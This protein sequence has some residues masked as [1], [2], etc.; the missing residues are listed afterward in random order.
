MYVVVSPQSYV[1]LR[2]QVTLS[3]ADIQ[4]KTTPAK[5]ANIRMRGSL[6]FNLLYKH[7]RDRLPGSVSEF[8][9][10]NRKLLQL[11]VQKS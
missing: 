5:P 11:T 10:L 9:R 2:V 8:S 1:A 3:L 6:A 4:L 7:P